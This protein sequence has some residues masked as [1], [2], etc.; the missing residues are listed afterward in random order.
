[1][2]HM[3]FLYESC[4]LRDVERPA[5][6]RYRPWTLSVFPDLDNHRES[7]PTSS[8]PIS[9]I[10][11]QVLAF[12]GLASYSYALPRIYAPAFSGAKRS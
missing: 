1:M 9:S 10:I 7:P 11:S 6:G 3:R 12:H 8:A 4:S 2:I 5:L